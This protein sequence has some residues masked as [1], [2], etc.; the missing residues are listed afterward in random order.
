MLSVIVV[1][2]LGEAAESISW[3]LSDLIMLNQK[4]CCAHFVEEF[5]LLC[6]G[7]SLLWKFVSVGTTRLFLVYCW[8]KKHKNTQKFTKAIYA[9]NR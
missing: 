8:K 2:E 4:K 7:A 6:M 5:D 3:V 9:N 1:M